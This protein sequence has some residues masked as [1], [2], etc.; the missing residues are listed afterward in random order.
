MMMN[1]HS[2]SNLFLEHKLSAV[3]L[4]VC[5]AVA[6]AHSAT[7]VPITGVVTNSTT[8][9]PAAGN[10]VVLIALRQGMPEIA[11]TT[12][13]AKGHF[14]IESPDP[15]K[16]LL[17]VDHQGATYFQAAPPNMRNVDIQVYDVAKTV[18]DVTTEVSALRI[19]TNQQGIY[20]LQTFFINNLSNPPRTQFSDRSYEVYIPP[21][22]SSMP[23]RLWDLD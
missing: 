8:R 18:P 19:Q 1:S 9:Q 15:G 3:T 23:Q 21:A 4:F 17:R 16:H 12:T 5:L 7:A 6:G 11:K 20:V 2:R 14:S 13:D 10:P 22:Q